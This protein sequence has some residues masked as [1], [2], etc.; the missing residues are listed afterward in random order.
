MIYRVAVPVRY[1]DYG[2]SDT[3]ELSHPLDVIVLIA[4]LLEILEFG[5]ITITV[6]DAGR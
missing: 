4:E 1:F 5:D 2:R 6:K 3:T